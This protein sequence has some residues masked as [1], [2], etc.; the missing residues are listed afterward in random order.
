MQVNGKPHPH[1]PG[2]T[3]HALLRELDVQP[4]R[5]AIAV[6]DDFYPG[7]QAPDREL[8]EADVVEIVKVIGGG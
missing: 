6:N 3:L 5:V 2:L 8:K 4:E 1:A 7:G